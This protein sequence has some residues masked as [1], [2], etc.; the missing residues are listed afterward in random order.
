MIRV[1]EVEEERPPPRQETWTEWLLGKYLRIW[2]AVGCLF[3]DVMLFLWLWSAIEIKAA[4]VIIFIACA[5]IEVFVY[6]RLWGPG[7]RFGPEPEE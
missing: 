5:L 1:V 3:L 4:A 2:Y 7:G 6:S